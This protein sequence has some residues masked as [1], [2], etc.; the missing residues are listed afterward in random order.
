MSFSQPQVA[1]GQ[2]AQL[3]ITLTNPYEPLDGYSLDLLG[4]QFTNHLP[5]GLSLSG[6]NPVSN[7]CGGIFS[8]EDGASSFSL[9]GVALPTLDDPES[10]SCTIIVNVT[11]RSRG[12]YINEILAGDVTSVAL[13]VSGGSNLESVS[14]TLLVTGSSNT[15]ENSDE[16]PGTLPKTGFSPGVITVLPEQP[17]SK[18]YDSSQELILEIPEIG[19]KTTIVGVPISENGWDLTWLGNQAGWLNGTVFPTWPGNSVITAHVWDALDQPGPFANLYQLKYGDQII[20]H[21]WGQSY[22]YE[23]R[24]IDLDVDPN[25]TSVLRHEDFPWLTLITCHGFN[26]DK[27]IYDKRFVLRAIQVSID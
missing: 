20:I 9:S 12:S 3:S 7:S 21:A 6:P 11:G 16:L 15:D 17:L 26:S 4:V 14:T 19:L 27:D 2:Q 1:A 18:I 22:I 5:S 10:N 8:D 13:G 25:D 24:N 23:V